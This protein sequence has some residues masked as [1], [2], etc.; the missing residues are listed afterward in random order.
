MTMFAMIADYG[1]Y[2]NQMQSG[3]IRNIMEG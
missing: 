2:R 1:Y 3:L